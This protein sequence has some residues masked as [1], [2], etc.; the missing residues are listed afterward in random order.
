MLAN[1][2]HAYP[3]ISVSPESEAGA[4]TTSGMETGKSNKIVCVR[5]VG[6]W[7]TIVS[8]ALTAVEHAISTSV[9]GNAASIALTACQGSAPK[10]TSISLLP[11]LPRFSIRDTKASLAMPSV[12]SSQSAILPI[13]IAHVGAQAASKHS[14]TS[15][16]SKRSLPCA[17]LMLSDSDAAGDASDGDADGDSELLGLLEPFSIA[18]GSGSVCASNC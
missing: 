15:N 4:P 11:R 13:I 18:Y 3:A 16:A 1:Q 2:P 7:R 6:R 8:M 9:E 14:G 17:G 10:A 12:V 5:V